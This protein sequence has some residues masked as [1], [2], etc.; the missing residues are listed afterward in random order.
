[1]GDDDLE[2]DTLLYRDMFIATEFLNC[3]H[4][5][6]LKKP[7]IERTKLRMFLNVKMRKRKFNFDEYKE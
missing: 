1:M 3:T 5:E 2:T 7:K 6:F 4:E